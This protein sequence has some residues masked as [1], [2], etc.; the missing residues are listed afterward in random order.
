M[1]QLSL[2]FDAWVVSDISFLIYLFIKAFASSL[3]IFRI[4]IC[5]FNLLPSGLTLVVYDCFVNSYED[6]T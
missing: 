2:A 5:I 3:Y 6:F 4:F 1:V